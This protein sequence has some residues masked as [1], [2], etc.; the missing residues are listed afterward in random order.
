M[1]YP[2]AI[3]YLEYELPMYQKIG[4]KAANMGLQN[5]QKLC[6]YLGNPQ[7]QFRSIHIAGTNGKGS[8]AHALSA[9]LQESGYKVGL[10]TS[11]H[12][13]DLRER[14]KI[15]GQL[16]SK[17]A[18]T[19]F[20]NKHQTFLEHLKPSF[21]EVLVAMG[22]DYF[23][24]QKVDI[25]IIETGLGGRLD[26]TN[27]IMPTLSIITNIGKEHVQFLGNTLAKIAYEKAGIIKPK[28]PVVIGETHP[29][30]KS[31]FE[32]VANKNS[33]SIYFAQQ[34]YTT[35]NELFK[36]D[37]TTIDVLHHQKLLYPQLQTDLTGNFQRN[38]I[39]TVLHA[40]AILQ[41]KEIFIKKEN[42][43]NA[44][45]KVRKLSNLIGRWQILKARNPTIIA[46][47]AHNLA[48]WKYV[49]KQLNDIAD[50][51]EQIHMI[52]G[53]VKGKNEAEILSLLPK[54]ATYYWCAPNLERALPA[55]ILQKKA[56]KLGL[57]GE[58]YSS[59]K[60]A[61]IEA[62]RIAKSKDLIFIGGSNFVVAEVLGEE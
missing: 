55:N 41:E 18:V 58:V 45:K 61:F 19:A 2:Q 51:Y 49:V 47:S 7:R 57:N 50:N 21:F 31:V 37:S 16:M 1:T 26:A 11:P 13:N 4:A 20:I 36:L 40:V 10:H 59:E 35:E 48:A 28:I 46:D 44:L 54:T 53:M 32:E 22:F 12:Y 52:I 33:S 14:N 27:I 30:T 56:Y 39:L 6:A 8:T 34:N 15:N 38:N 25:A 5:I 60:E 9:I 24:Q 29:E 3:H 23:A 17:T 62:K 43:Y 42:V